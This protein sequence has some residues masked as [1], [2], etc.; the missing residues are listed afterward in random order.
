MTRNPRFSRCNAASV[1]AY[2]K[3]E[4]PTMSRDLDA[5]D[6]NDLRSAKSKIIQAVCNH[7]EIMDDVIAN[8]SLD[9]KYHNEIVNER[10]NRKLE[11]QT[12]LNEQF[13]NR[14]QVRLSQTEAKK[15]RDEAKE[16]RDEA[17]KFK[18]EAE[19]SRAEAKAL[20]EKAKKKSIR[21]VA[22]RRGIVD[23]NR[24]KLMNKICKDKETYKKVVN[25]PD[26]NEADKED[27]EEFGGE[28]MSL[29]EVV[30]FMIEMGLDTINKKAT[31]EQLFAAL[32][33]REEEGDIKVV[34]AFEDHIR[35]S[36][37]LKKEYADYQPDSFSWWKI[38]V[39][40][41]AS[42][43]VMYSYAVATS[44][45]RHGAIQ[46]YS[47]GDGY[48]ALDVAQKLASVVVTC[49]VVMYATCVKVVDAHA[50]VFQAVMTKIMHGTYS[51]CV[52]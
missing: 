40:L 8:E 49:V 14:F 24:K 46:L 6:P 45:G 28:E 22:S 30:C 36:K 32:K 43:M 42:L 23:A 33:K 25:D 19:K 7:P 16:A 20:A 18:A 10:N 15:A 11:A 12:A 51:V 21:E 3:S 26:I 37:V 9:Y 48:S 50:E 31:E 39:L 27:L 4:Y 35:I 34:G 2:L 17:E 47:V 13:E 41:F 52:P 29:Q 44:D 5:I 1:L 38:S